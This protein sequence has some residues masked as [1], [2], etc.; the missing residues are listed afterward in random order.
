MGFSLPPLRPLGFNILVVG[1]FI[2]WGFSMMCW[3]PFFATFFRRKLRKESAFFNAGLQVSLMLLQA[4]KSTLL[5]PFARSQSRRHGIVIG[6][7]PLLSLPRFSAK[8]RPGTRPEKMGRVLDF[9]F[10]PSVHWALIF[11]SS[12]DSLRWAFQLSSV[13]RLL[14][15]SLEES[16]AKN[17][18]FA[19]L[20]KT[21]AVSLKRLF[22]SALPVRQ[23]IRQTPVCLAPAELNPGLPKVGIFGRGVSRQKG[24]PSRCLGTG[25]GLLKKAGQKK[26]IRLTDMNHPHQD[27]IEPNIPDILPGRKT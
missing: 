19:S 22:A 26:R 16:G 1:R 5:P 10:R 17:F 23:V 6:C 9:P 27:K 24:N 7:P 3:K 25:I 12:G 2:S 4:L 8:K 13:N 21:S 11:S 14:P 18:L 20:V 15:L